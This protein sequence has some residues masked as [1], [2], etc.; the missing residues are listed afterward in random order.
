MDTG[1]LGATLQS[2]HSNVAKRPAKTLANVDAQLRYA[3]TLLSK[4][5]AQQQVLKARQE[6]TQEANEHRERSNRATSEK[7]AQRMQHAQ[8][9]QERRRQQLLEK[10]QHLMEAH[11]ARAEYTRT[12][13]GD[14]GAQRRG[15]MLEKDERIKQ[16]QARAVST[17]EERNQE[18]ERKRAEREAMRAAARDEAESLRLRGVEASRQARNQKDMAVQ[19][20]MQEQAEMRERKEQMLAERLRKH[21][22]K[23]AATAQYHEDLRKFH[24][25]ME[26]KANEVKA[27]THQYVQTAAAR[28]HADEK[29]Q[30]QILQIRAEIAEMA[31]NVPGA[32]APEP[33]LDE[34]LESQSPPKANA[35]ARSQPA[36]PSSA[37]PRSPGNRFKGGPK[38]GFEPPSRTAAGAPA[39]ASGAE[40]A[41]GPA[42]YSN[43]ANK[44]RTNNQQDGA[45][46]A[47]ALVA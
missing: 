16:A 7:A 15:I 43:L 29:L 1:L 14:Q 39:A 22:D 6:A 38:S 5:Q 19:A 18:A 25:E 31:N 32:P 44:K 36:S 20:K 17:R 46:G 45:E 42:T 11:Q 9:V 30:R 41:A 34:T 28:G 37:A 8:E 2:V 12:L 24:A 33:G 3:D 27:L 10:E 23:Q 4:Q 26:R 35:R 13:R 47:G 40:A 21:A